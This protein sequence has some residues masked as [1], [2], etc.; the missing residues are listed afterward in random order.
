ME[1]RGRMNFLGLREQID[2]AE[3]FNSLQSIFDLVGP[4][5]MPLRHVLYFV[6]RQ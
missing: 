3:F 4:I 5:G 2:L 1:R 6:T